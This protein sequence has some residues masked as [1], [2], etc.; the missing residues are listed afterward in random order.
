MS[1]IFGFFYVKPA[2]DITTGRRADL[3]TLDATLKST[4]QIQTLISQTEN[5]LNAID[6]AAQKRFS[7]F[8]PAT[9]DSIRLANNIQ[10]IGQAHTIVIDKIKGSD[11][12]R[13]APGGTGIQA[14]ASDINAAAKAKKYVTTKTEFSFTTSDDLF[15]AFLADLEKNLGLMN[16]T[17]LSFTSAPEAVDPLKVKRSTAPQYLYTIIIETYSLK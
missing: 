3:T 5:T 6:P 14:V 2:Y 10:H 12:A 13:S 17:S 15:R 8:L 7:V 9:A 1:L 11:Q 4:S 16:V